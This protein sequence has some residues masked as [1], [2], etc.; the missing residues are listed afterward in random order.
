METSLRTR[1]LWLTVFGI[2]FGYLEA[3]VVVYLRALYYPGGFRFPTVL[4]DDR[5]LLVEVGRE[6]ATLLMLWGVAMVA[7][8]EAWSR[9][10]VFAFLFGVWDIV[11]YITLWGVLSWPESLLTW[12]V[13]FLIPL[14]WAGPV[15]SAVV[16]AASL[17]VAGALILKRRADGIRPL[18]T[19]WVWVGAVLSLL[20][21]LASF[22]ANH[23]VVQAQ[24]I[25]RTFPWAVYLA[26]LVLGWVVFW[27]SFYRKAHAPPVA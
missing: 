4:P 21:L 22:M 25:P 8:R 20:L 23:G 5:I 11:F 9:F 3:A 19:W 26:G 24:E 14:V 18:T 16:V 15:L 1:L 27:V 2:A 10:G 17:V 6:L 13:L 12:D 7:S